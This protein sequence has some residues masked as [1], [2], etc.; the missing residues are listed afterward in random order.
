MTKLTQLDCANMCEV[1]LLNDNGAREGRSADCFV[2][3]SRLHY[4]WV[5]QTV[6][7]VLFI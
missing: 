1:F 6:P 7:F 5:N 2:Q 4:S 3:S